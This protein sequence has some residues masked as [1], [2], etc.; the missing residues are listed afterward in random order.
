MTVDPAERTA[1]LARRRNLATFLLANLAF[2]YGLAVLYFV[3][4]FGDTR[5]FWLPWSQ[6]IY[7]PTLPL[8]VP[9]FIYSPVVALVL[10]PFGLLPEPVFVL[11]WTALAVATYVWLL[12]P[13]PPAPR[14]AAI[15][16]GCAFALNGNIE[17]ALA[18]MVVLAMTRPAIWLTAAFTKVT[19]FIGFAWFM[20]KRDAVAM[21]T[22]A[23]VGV[24][25]VGLSAL[26]LPGAWDTWLQMLWSFRGQ[27]DAP[28]V[29]IPSVPLVP[30]LCIAA[31]V[32]VW[33][34]AKGRPIVLPVVLL[35]AQ[36]DWEPWMLGYLAAV[37]RLR[38]LEVGGESRWATPPRPRRPTLPHRGP[39][40]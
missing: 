39:A 10:R 31:G 13:L 17:W 16:A 1:L 37:P 12:W 40:R 7:D 23:V 20:L 38:D 14:L 27:A 22:T 24:G 29:V 21:A 26:A 15:G 6:P 34:V 9:H 32:M 2:W 35:L 28:G 25:L 36:P 30:R 18:L 4:P 19:P 5:S 8:R 3:G 11:A 33:G